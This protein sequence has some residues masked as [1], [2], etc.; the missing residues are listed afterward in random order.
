MGT[1]N[2][3][4]QFVG[5]TN[6]KGSW[7]RLYINSNTDNQLQ[8]CDF[9][10]GGRTSNNYTAVITLHDAQVGI[11][12]CKISGGLGTGIF[13]NSWSTPCR[14]TAFNNN[15]VEGFEN[16][17]PVIFKGDE[18]LGLIEKFDMTSDFT[19]NTKKYIELDP[20]S[21]KDIT[22]NK[23]TVPYF[24]SNGFY[25]IDYTLTINKGVTFY[26]ADE[27]SFCEWGGNGRI[28]MNGTETEKV[29]VTRMPGTAQYWGTIYFSG[30]K[31]SIFRH[32]IFEYGGAGGG[33]NGAFWFLNTTDIS[34]D[35]VDINNS[36]THGVYI[37]S[38]D[39][40]LNQSNVD[41]LDNYKGDVYVNSNSLK[42]NCNNNPIVLSY[43]P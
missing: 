3:R 4:I 21:K 24:L 43:I 30:L 8:Y 9:I 34:M 11:S 40:R 2:K 29:K 32:C 1:A 26:I 27:V 39:Y 42:P 28:I 36:Y 25:R 17:P 6:T 7:E 31:G 18:S 37:S 5:A 15:V 13:A 19:K 33:V 38:C 10:N 16:Y 20:K 22:F 12:H 14:I 35:N 23:T 41:F